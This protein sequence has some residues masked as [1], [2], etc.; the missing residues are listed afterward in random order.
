[1]SAA[2]YSKLFTS[3]LSPDETDAKNAQSMGNETALMFLR[4]GDARLVSDSS[5]RFN[6]SALLNSA[7]DM[8]TSTVCRRPKPQNTDG[9][10]TTITITVIWPR[11]R[12][13]A[14]AR[15]SRPTCYTYRQRAGQRQDVK[16]SGTQCFRR[17]RSSTDFAVRSASGRSDSI[18]I[19][20]LAD[21]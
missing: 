2:K 12:R 6:C 19:L 8:L 7:D 20:R 9:V 16:K 5:Q 4:T 21:G 13:S 3:F 17:G 11:P 15:V 18:R 14:T 10:C 1:M